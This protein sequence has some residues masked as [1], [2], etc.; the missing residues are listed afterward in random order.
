[1]VTAFSQISSKRK[2][3]IVLFSGIHTITS[4]SDH[5]EIA[6]KVTSAHAGP[7]TVLERSSFFEDV[8]LSAGGWTFKIWKDN[9]DDP[10][11][12]SSQ[13][14]QIYTS[15]NFALWNSYGVF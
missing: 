13:A 15:G 4:D 9:V 2:V 8:I 3:K 7:I 12:T 10:L 14:Q 11:F 1:M 6:E 5:P